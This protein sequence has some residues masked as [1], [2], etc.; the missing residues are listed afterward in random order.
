MSKMDNREL[1]DRIFREHEKCT[2]YKSNLGERGLFEQV[3]LNERFFA[4]DQWHGA[5]ISAKRPLV[6]HNIIK[7]IGDYKQSVIEG[8]EYNVR[9]SANGVAEADGDLLSYASA[10]KRK[11][12][13]EAQRI[14]LGL[15]LLSAHFVCAKDAAGLGDV[16]SKALSNAFI[17]GTGVVYTYWDN[18]VDTG[19]YA[20]GRKTERVMGDVRAKCIDIECIDFAEPEEQDINAQSYIIIKSRMT[21]RHARTI[22]ERFGAS[23]EEIENICG[24]FAEAGAAEGDTEQRV[25]VLTKL[26]RYKNKRG[27]HSVSAVQVCRGCVIRP[28]WNLRIGR[29]PIS[30]FRWNERRGCIYGDS[31]VTYLIPN[32]IAVNR[33]L[34]AGV[35]ATMLNGMPMML[36]NGNTVK[37]KITN[38]PGQI[39]TFTGDTE[40]FENAVKYVAPPAFSENMANAVKSLIDNTLELAGASR[41][42]LGVDIMNNA[43]AIDLL[44]RAN[45][46]PLKPMINRYASFICDAA[47]VFAEFFIGFYGNRDVMVKL[48]GR[49]IYLPF[50]S[51]DYQGLAINVTTDNDIIA[52]PNEEKENEDEREQSV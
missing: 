5:K 45:A 22:A 44:G 39:I 6:R 17:S 43:T 51:A 14:N 35:W 13:N 26:E 3:K 9:F 37:S 41:T 24:D 46:A 20:D 28:K 48:G 49:R 50:N 33:M 36:V 7:R 19:F 47:A 27:G 29:Y 25:T 1:I 40:D 11:T 10:D 31:E 15:Q 34:T 8:G 4:G 23:S 30:L 52:Q 21:V 42:A 32:Q 12:L 38:S 16:L 18:E 2:E